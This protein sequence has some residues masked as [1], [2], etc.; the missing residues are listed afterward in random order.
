M[1]PALWA[2][3]GGVAALLLVLVGVALALLVGGRRE[4]RER[5]ALA[6]A[7]ADVEA[8][9]AQLD[10][11]STE[12]VTSRGAAA[13]V[14]PQVEYVITSAGEPATAS[15]DMPPVDD[16]AVLSVTLG[17]PLVKVA[18]LGFGVRRALSAESRNRIAFAMR[19]EVKRARKERRR[20]ARRTRVAQ[21]RTA[22]AEEAA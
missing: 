5:D 10:E 11:L 3:L 16:R 13:L 4:A 8:L 9:R 21:A 20:A 15:A 6:A 7:R 12:L 18:A 22:G 19:R 2:A 17:E 1:N 14:A